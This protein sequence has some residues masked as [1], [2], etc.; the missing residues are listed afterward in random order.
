MDIFEAENSFHCHEERDSSLHWERFVFV[1][2]LVFEE[3]FI[4]LANLL[5]AK[6]ED[7]DQRQELRN[8]KWILIRK[9]QVRYN[10]FLLLFL[11]RYLLIILILNYRLLVIVDLTAVVL[12]FL[13][14]HLLLVALHFSTCKIPELAILPAGKPTTL[15][16][17]FRSAAQSYP[18]R[19]RRPLDGLSLFDCKLVLEERT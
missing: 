1:W 6:R 3:E 4:E 2:D 13:G 8:V 18:G 19:K 10:L 15:V 14:V 16:V 7:V 12:V 17:N 5:A 9:P 11:D